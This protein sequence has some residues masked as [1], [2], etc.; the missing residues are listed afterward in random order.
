MDF[1]FPLST[2]IKWPSFFNKTIKK[3]FKEIIGQ[4]FLV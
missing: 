4:I 2:E 3:L 1:M